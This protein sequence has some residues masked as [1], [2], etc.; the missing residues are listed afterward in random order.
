M[1]LNK[2]FDSFQ[3]KKIWVIGASSGIGKALAIKLLKENAFVYLSARKLELLNEIHS[4]FPNNSV[5]KKLD[6]TNREEINQ[7]VNEIPEIDLIIYLAADYT[8]MGIDNL[9]LHEIDKMININLIGA[10]NVTTAIIPKLKKQGRGHLS[11]VASI[12]GYIGLPNSAIY[13][14]TK[15]ALINFSESIF[16]ECKKY[17]IDISVVNPGFVKTNLT[18]KNTFEMPFIMTPDQAASAIMK[19]YQKGDFVIVFP[20]IFSY[21]FRFIR[22]L[23]YS[24]HLFLTKRLIKA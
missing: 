20:K 7:I 13:G 10:L 23:P 22:I 6:V 3:N 18:D 16:W 2:K 8:P 1:S 5:V 14:A 24:I 19:G 15:A 4:T 21:F 17:N 12:A 9:D 11:I